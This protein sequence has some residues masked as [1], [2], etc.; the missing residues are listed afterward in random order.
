MIYKYLRLWWLYTVYST[1]IGFVSR[2]GVVIFMLGKILRFFF[3]FFFLLIIASKTKSIAGYTLWQIIFFFATYNL[4]DTLPQ[5]LMR[6]V[7]RFRSQVV[8]GMFDYTLM[9]PFSPLFRVLFGGGDALDLSVLILS[10]AFIVYSGIRLE[11]ITL[12]S[13]IF[14]LILI[15]NSFL[16]ALAFHIFVVSMGVLTTEVDNTIMLY[17]DLTQMGRFPVDIYRQP[18]RN[19]ITF[20][21]PVGIM[22]TF[23]VKAILGLLSVQLILTA[24]VIAVLL[25]GASLFFW[26]YALKE[27]ASASS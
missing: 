11:G 20:I 7:Y 5:L 13:V 23:P 15:I 8:T 22:M 4:I 25:L 2:L 10:L 9:K 26:R 1:Q 21:I 12:L 19:F 6:E 17:R 18:L 14:Y 3:F 27:Y 16:I 24:F